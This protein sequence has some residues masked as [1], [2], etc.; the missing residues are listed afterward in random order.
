MSG[1]DPRTSG[2]AIKA[3]AAAPPST[4]LAVGSA[5]GAAEVV[6]SRIDTAAT[7]VELPGGGQVGFPGRRM[8]ALYGHPGAT[9]L[10]ALG[11]QPLDAT[12]ARA[13]AVAAS[14]SSP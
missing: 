5:F 1:P 13:K 6:R 2:E 14:Y 4:V 12:I 8:I 9:S 7:G 3:L 11:E 10:G